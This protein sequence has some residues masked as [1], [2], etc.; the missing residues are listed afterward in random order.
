MK[1]VLPEQRHKDVKKQ[2]IIQVPEC[3]IKVSLLVGVSVPPGTQQPTSPKENHTKIS[4]SYKTDWP[5][6]SGYLLALVTY[7]NPLLLSMLATQ[8]GTFHSRAG[9]ILLLSGMGKNGGGSFLL[10]RFSCFLCSTSTSYLV[11]LHIIPAWP[12]SIY[13]KHD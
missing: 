6:S 8:L 7:I 9:Y 3:N 4:I 2:S 12:I 10:P 13:L 1:N 5:I 11:D